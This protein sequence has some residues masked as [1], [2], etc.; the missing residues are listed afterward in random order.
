MEQLLWPDRIILG[1]G[2]S[3]QLAKFQPMLTTR[4]PVV[5]ASLLNQAG[6]VGAALFAAEVES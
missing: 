3:R 4:A 2:V 6:L 5:A 1:G